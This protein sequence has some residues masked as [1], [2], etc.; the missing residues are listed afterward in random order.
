[1]VSRRSS[2]VNKDKLIGKCQVIA[3]MTDR[4]GVKQIAE[5]LMELIENLYK[6]E[7]GFKKEDK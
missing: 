5:I 6:N 3:E 7:I 1:M 2:S 4:E